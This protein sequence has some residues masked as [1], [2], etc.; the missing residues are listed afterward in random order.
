MSQAN[1]SETRVKA[2]SPT[3]VLAGVFIYATI[4]CGAFWWVLLR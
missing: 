4:V 3:W 1:L 2:P